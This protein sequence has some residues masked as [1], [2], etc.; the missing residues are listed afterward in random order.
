MAQ[1]TFETFIQGERDRLNKAREDALAKLHEQE[2]LIASVDRELAAIHAYEQVKS[3]KRAQADRKPRA[4]SGP[5][6]PRGARGETI[7]QITELLAQGDLD[8][9]G[10]IAEMNISDDAARRSVYA[11]LDK[12]KKDGLIAYADKKRGPFKLA[13]QTRKGEDVAA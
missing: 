13:Q 9:A 12:M 11:A 2:E 8:T 10:I 1:Q 7:K 4:P 5:R 6:A 3:G